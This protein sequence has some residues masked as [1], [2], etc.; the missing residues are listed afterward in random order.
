MSLV[1]CGYVIVNYGRLE[2]SVL[3]PERIARWSRWLLP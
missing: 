1:P 2:L 3:A